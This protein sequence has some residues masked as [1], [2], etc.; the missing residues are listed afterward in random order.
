MRGL[1]GIPPHIMCYKRLEYIGVLRGK[2]KS[3]E[4][5]YSCVIIIIIVNIHVICDIQTVISFV[6]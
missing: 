4:N 5:S 2:K 1:K 3:L 6:K